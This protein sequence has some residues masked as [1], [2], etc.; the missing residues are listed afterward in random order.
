VFRL[1]LCA[2]F[3]LMKPPDVAIDALDNICTNDDVIECKRGLENRRHGRI[4]NQDPRLLERCL[5]FP[6]PFFNQYAA[7]KQ[8]LC[9]PANIMSDRKHA[10]FRRVCA[11]QRSVPAKPEPPFALDA[12]QV[13]GFREAWRARHF[14]AHST[15]HAPHKEAE[16]LGR[17]D[18]TLFAKLNLCRSHQ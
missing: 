13:S 4:C 5:K 11:R 9:K 16:V 12:A 7:G 6:W 15:P 8:I 18:L 1:E 17:N 10:A 14:I 3:N 2:R